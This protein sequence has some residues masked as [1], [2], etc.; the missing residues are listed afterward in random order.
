MQ[1]LKALFGKK[2][3]QKDVAQTLPANQ[4]MSASPHTPAPQAAVTRETV[5]PSAVIR[6][7]LV[8]VRVD[9]ATC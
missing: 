9:G 1:F 6:A 3:S 5:N 8:P 2:Q 7:V 4:R